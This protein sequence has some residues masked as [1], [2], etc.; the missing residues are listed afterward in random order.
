MFDKHTKKC[1]TNWE[2]Y[3]NIL[4]RSKKGAING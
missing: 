2:K 1:L 4:A 3:D